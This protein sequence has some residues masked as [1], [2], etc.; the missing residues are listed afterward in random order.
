MARSEMPQI[1]TAEQP[2][3][4]A[5]PDSEDEARIIYKTAKPHD[6]SRYNAF[7]ACD[8]L[9]AAGELDPHE[10]VGERELEQRAIAVGTDNQIA[11]KGLK[12]LIERRGDDPTLRVIEAE[13]ALYGP[14]GR[15]M[16]QF[17]RW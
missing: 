5:R 17:G 9:R 12:D 6:V 15:G 16:H 14:G 7:S 13:Y 11:I 10:E 2:F 1:T 3:W 4:L 8:V